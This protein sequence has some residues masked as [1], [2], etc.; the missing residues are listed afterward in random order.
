MT[1]DP[2]W[3]ALVVLTL[4]RASMGFQFQAPAAA[5]PVLVGQM[6]LD[7]AQVGA[8][9]GLYML[10][11][12]AL[13]LPGGVLGRRFGDTRVVIAGLFL[14]VAGGAISAIADDYMLLMAG[15]L[16]AGLGAVLLNVL[17]TKMVTDWFAGR[18]I[19]LAMAV[20]V[21]AFP[22]G[23]GIAL[24]SLG[25]LAE[26]TGW[27]ASFL[28]TALAALAASSLLAVLYPRHPNDQGEPSAGERPRISRREVLLVCLPG[29]IWGLYNGAFTVTFA[30]APTLL[31][32]TGLR[33]AEAGLVVGAA[34]WL[35]VA[36][37]LAG[38]IAAQREDWRGLLMTSGILV[39]GVG[40]L[41]LPSVDP[42]PILLLIGL[43]QGLP[44]PII[45]S[46]PATVLRPESRA[47]GMGVFFTWLYVGHALL[48]P[49]AGWLQDATGS[50][51]APFYC[52]AVLVLCILPL[53]A[54]FRETR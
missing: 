23:I 20:F 2:R 13:A 36:S 39:W 31:T 47:V 19:V 49:A 27:P 42:V 48:P 46:M 10:P 11:G 8:L 4:A 7:Y 29:A 6:G 52:S 41:L 35:V 40:L 43:F 21:N 37:V 54:V 44:V 26:S 38:G 45:M 5:S 22:V 30:F 34:T 15:R 28:V 50:A 16:V 18:E 9:V 1:L 12:I 17:M 25:W 53:Y 33:A 14:M 3:L 51:A 24:L 32:G